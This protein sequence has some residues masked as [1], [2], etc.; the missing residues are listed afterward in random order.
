MAVDTR[1]IEIVVALA[2]GSGSAWFMA[3][4]SLAREFDQKLRRMVETYRKQHEVVVDKLNASHALARKELEHQR[5]TAPRH[6]AGAANDQRA[7]VSRLE[8]QLKT[9]YAELDRLRLEVK[10]PAPAGSPKPHNGFAD[11]Q[12]FEPRKSPQK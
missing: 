6:G 8:E 12:P 10:G 4:R 3:R 7:A 11:T 2:V 5:K 1:I 9:A